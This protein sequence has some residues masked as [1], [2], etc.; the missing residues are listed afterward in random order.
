MPFF[1]EKRKDEA[2]YKIGLCGK[3]RFASCADNLT[4]A[5]I[6]LSQYASLLLPKKKISSFVFLNPKGN[7]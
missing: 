4:A 5:C 3:S 6:S 7:I 1:F 2:T